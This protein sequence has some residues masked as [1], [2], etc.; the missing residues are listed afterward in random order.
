MPMEVLILRN[1][2]AFVFAGE[3]PNDGIR[4][5]ASPNCLT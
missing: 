4:C 5:S 2:H 1:E 3:L